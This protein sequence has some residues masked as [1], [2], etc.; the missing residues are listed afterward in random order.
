MAL[1]TWTGSLAGAAAF[2]VMTGAANAGRVDY[3][4]VDIWDGWFDYSPDRRAAEDG[5]ESLLP[6]Q[7]RLD[8]LVSRT[9]LGDM[10]ALRDYRIAYDFTVEMNQMKDSAGEPI[11]DE[12]GFVLC[13]DLCAGWFRHG[14]FAL[15]DFSI[16]DWVANPVFP[17]GE[18]SRRPWMGDDGFD[19]YD[20]TMVAGQYEPFMD[21]L[22]PTS[23]ELR[24]YDEYDPE[25]AEALRHAWYGQDWI[26]SGHLDGVVR[27]YTVAPVPLPAAAPLL[28]LGL[29]WLAVVRRKRGRAG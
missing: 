20:G 17:G 1:S 14:S 3:M 2:V 7:M 25:L 22:R 15:T 6:S 26:M 12:Y 13:P 23:R 24:A 9:F 19:V 5:V 8:A 18:W 27:V 21:A 28:L 4:R 11:L 16:D 29:G 10:S